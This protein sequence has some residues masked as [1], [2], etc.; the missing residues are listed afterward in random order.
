MLNKELKLK[1]FG[2]PGNWMVPH[3]E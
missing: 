1:N 3:V 2:L